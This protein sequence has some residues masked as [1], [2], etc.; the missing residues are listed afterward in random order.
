MRLEHI[1]N[2][3]ESKFRVSGEDFQSLETEALASAGEYGYEVVVI[4]FTDS[5]NLYNQFL[6]GWIN[7]YRGRK[8]IF[9]HKNVG[10]ANQTAL[11]VAR[12]HANL[13]NLTYGGEHHKFVTSWNE[14]LIE[15]SAISTYSSSWGRIINSHPFEF[16]IAAKAED[17]KKTVEECMKRKTSTAC[18]INLVGNARTGKTAVLQYL[19]QIGIGDKG[20]RERLTY[21]TM[22]TYGIWRYDIED[23]TNDIATALMHRASNNVLLLDE[24][25]LV[26]P[27]LHQ[28]LANLFDVIVYVSHQPLN[29]ISEY[30][31]TI[32]LAL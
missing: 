7:Q 22:E 13:A 17:L 16:Y 29:F 30:S 6:Y 27:K 20:S 32:T 18:I 5:Q 12:A 15:A 11:M 2:D 8:V 4:D 25:G 24:A 21:Q 28:T 26:T 19:S 10:Q 1:L 9:F 23:R 14:Q 3:R 31:T